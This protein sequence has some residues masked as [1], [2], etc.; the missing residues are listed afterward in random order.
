M[1]NGSVQAAYTRAKRKCS[2]GIVSDAQMAF[3]E[4]CSGLTQNPQIHQGCS[5]VRWSTKPP[6]MNTIRMANDL[7][8][9]GPP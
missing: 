5:D 2:N 7:R 9:A 6:L 4:Y 3:W 1:R 8:T